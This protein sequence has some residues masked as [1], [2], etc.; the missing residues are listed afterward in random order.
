MPRGSRP[1]EGGAPWYRR[2]SVA[3]AALLVVVAGLGFGAFLLLSSSEPSRPAPPD[4]KARAAVDRFD[5]AALPL[6]AA[7][8]DVAL[9]M[10][11]EAEAFDGGRLSGEALRARCDQWERTLREVLADFTGLPTPER[12]QE[13]RAL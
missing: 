8:G 7:L 9:E 6:D 1:P 10:R 13:S 3:V 5:R 12:L 2:R 11:Q 4:P